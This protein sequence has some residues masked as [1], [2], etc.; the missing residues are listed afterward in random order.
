M[1]MAEE[2]AKASE[3]KHASSRMSKQNNN[4]FHNVDNK[5]L[6]NS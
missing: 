5:H 6:T 4:F 3:S 2:V 1:Q